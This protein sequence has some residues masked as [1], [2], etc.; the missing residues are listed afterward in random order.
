[1]LM[2]GV[3]NDGSVWKYK[4]GCERLEKGEMGARMGEG[5]RRQLLK[6]GQR[7]SQFHFI[8]MQLGRRA[9][10]TKGHCNM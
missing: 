6:L 8:W 2:M 5:A 10:V 3:M 9:K 7:A 1:M 4:K